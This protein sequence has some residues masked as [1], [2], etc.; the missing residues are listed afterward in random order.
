MPTA[1]VV[2][3][4]PQIRYATANLR[5]K[6]PQKTIVDIPMQIYGLMDGKKVLELAMTNM[7][8]M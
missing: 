2:L 5:K 6:Y 4:G 1:D 8:D 7:K 3:I